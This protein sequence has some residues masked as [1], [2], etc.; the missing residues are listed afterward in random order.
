VIGKGR[1]SQSSRPRPQE[2]EMVLTLSRFSGGRF[3]IP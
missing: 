3:Q 1:S 2:K